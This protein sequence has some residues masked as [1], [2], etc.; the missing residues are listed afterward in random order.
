MLGFRATS[1]LAI[2]SQPEN[3]AQK[4]LSIKPPLILG[5]EWLMVWLTGLGSRMV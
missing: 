3:E 2:F 1:T 5:S 4:Q